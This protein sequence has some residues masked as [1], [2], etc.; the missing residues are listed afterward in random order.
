MSK[1]KLEIKEEDIDRVETMASYGLKVEQIAAILKMSRKTFYRR[2]EENPKIE[3]ALEKGRS[4]AVYNVSQ[5]AYQ[6]AVS[7]KVPAMTMFWLKCR[8][9]WQESHKIIHEG[10][11]DFDKLSD[12]EIEK[13]LKQLENE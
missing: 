13:R 5:T 11:I 4:V 3:E 8:A 6:Q 1:G 7:G 10:K 9:K 12:D 2:M